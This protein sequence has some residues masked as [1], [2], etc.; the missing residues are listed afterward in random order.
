MPLGILRRAEHGYGT[1]STFLE[2]GA[3]TLTAVIVIVNL[4]VSALT[5]LM[6][7]SRT[8]YF[9]RCSLFKIDGMLLVY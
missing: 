1:L 3:L 6:Y 8:I 5:I 7:C 9:S 2:A 4:Q